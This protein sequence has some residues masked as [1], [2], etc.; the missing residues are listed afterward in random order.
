[1]LECNVTDQNALVIRAFYI[2]SKK[3]LVAVSLREKNQHPDIR[4]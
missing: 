1:M 4:L 3:K 2:L